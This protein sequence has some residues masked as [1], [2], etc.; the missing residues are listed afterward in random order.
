MWSRATGFGSRD[1]SARSD[2]VIA[3]PGRVVCR[4]VLGGLLHEY[5]LEPLSAA[6]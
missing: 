4:D 2:P 3:M 5:S 1:S 6:A